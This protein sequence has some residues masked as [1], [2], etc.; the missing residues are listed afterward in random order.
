MG[1]LVTLL[2]DVAVVVTE[3]P[4]RPLRRAG[5]AVLLAAILIS[6]NTYVDWF[7]SWHQPVLDAV[8][9]SF[10]E[11]IEAGPTSSSTGE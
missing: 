9:S 1:R 3:A 6:P 7:Q 10:L 8:T 11:S 5:A 4:M 2:L